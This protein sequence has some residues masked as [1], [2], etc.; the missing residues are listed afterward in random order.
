M[1]GLFRTSAGQSRRL[2]APIFTDY[3]GV[4]R[5]GESFPPSPFLQCTEGLENSRVQMN[6]AFGDALDFSRRLCGMGRKA[7]GGE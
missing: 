5:V 3:F 6:A 1:S 7:I 2:W 4:F